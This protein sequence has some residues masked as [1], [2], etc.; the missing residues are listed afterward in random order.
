MSELVDLKPHQDTVNKQFEEEFTSTL[1]AIEYRNKLTKCILLI[2]CLCGVFLLF[3]FVFLRGHMSVKKNWRDKYN[4]M[5]TI[6]AIHRIDG[7]GV[8]GCLEIQ[9]EARKVWLA[10]D[11][12]GDAVFDSYS[13]LKQF[14]RSSDDSARLPAA[15]VS[16]C[17][18]VVVTREESKL[19]V[20]DSRAKQL[21]TFR[22]AES[23]TIE[24]RV[25]IR[26]LNNPVGISL[27]SSAQ[28]HAYISDGRNRLFSMDL[29]SGLV[30]DSYLQISENS[31]EPSNIGIGS[32]QQAGDYLV[33]VNTKAANELLLLD[34]S[35]SCLKGQVDL[36]QLFDYMNEILQQQ[37][38]AAVKREM[39]I[40]AVA[41]D[42]K[43]KSLFVA[44]NGWPFIFELKFLERTFTR[45][46]VK[47][48]KS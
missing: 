26:G 11:Q 34:P 41:F 17:E 33:A 44:G 29:S 4:N 5:F 22:L 47:S 12:S 7:G 32:L 43:Q 24:D 31:G 21:V 48:P 42:N 15:W 3:K 38:V 39:T 46:P 35:T 6:V 23:L 30:E 10:K 28:D 8:S 2:L 40:S 1:K 16:G 45:K 25:P 18:L 19:Y 13:L 37:Q 36:N 14:N 9:Q 20:L 27:F